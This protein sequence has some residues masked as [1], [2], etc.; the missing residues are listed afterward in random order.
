M[1]LS[2]GP[3]RINA[4]V[5]A[6]DKEKKLAETLRLK[7]TGLPMESILPFV[8]IVENEPRGWE[9]SVK[10]QIYHM[11]HWG[12]MDHYRRFSNPE[13]AGKEMLALGGMLC[14]LHS[15][16]F[17]E[18]DRLLR[19]MKGGNTLR[20]ALDFSGRDSILSCTEDYKKL[21][22][23]PPFVQHLLP[24]MRKQ[25]RPLE[26]IPLDGPRPP[27]QQQPI[28][29]N[30]NS[31]RRATVEVSAVPAP[32]LEMNNGP[33]SSAVDAINNSN[34][35]LQQSWE[36]AGFVTVNKRKMDA[37][38]SVGGDMK[39]LSKNA[40]KKLKRQASADQN[41]VI[42]LSRYAQEKGKHLVYERAPIGELNDEWIVLVKLDGKRI[43][44]GNG[45][46]VEDGDKKAAITALEELKM[47][48]WY[49]ASLNPEK[50]VRGDDEGNG[51]G[52]ARLK[53]P[54]DGSQYITAGTA[55]DNL[56]LLFP[57]A[58]YKIAYKP[59]TSDKVLPLRL[60]LHV[61]K[62]EE[63]TTV[64]EMEGL[65]VFGKYA[66]AKDDCALK[67]LKKLG[68]VVRP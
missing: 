61:I 63:R 33:S 21:L 52:A 60:M 12:P 64:E 2:A 29:D 56:F 16:M 6:D 66:D 39:P 7:R 47:A 40:L 46:S 45:N 27:L 22:P 65:S 53:A 24:A 37:A 54:P 32:A 30:R 23:T 4:D 19:R 18:F 58:E 20:E 67:L 15:T 13:T 34:D 43:G 11:P 8:V 62:K 42:V 51:N 28:V 5:K 50:Q 14:C 10:N 41:P 3:E 31:Q 1:C 57:L 17:A 49:K 48:P 35:M 55:R 9:D 26:P 44:Q 25:S 59:L 36:S 38:H 68:Y